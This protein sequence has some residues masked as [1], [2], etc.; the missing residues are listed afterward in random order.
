MAAPAKTAAPPKMAR[1]RNIG[2]VAHIDA[3]KTTV[4]ERFLF[5]SGR[6]HKI[7]EVHDGEAQMDW[8]PQERERGITITAAATSIAWR[9]HDI[10]LIDTP[11]HVDFTIEVERIAARA[12]RRGGRVRRRVGRRAA[13][14]DGV[15]PGRQ[16]SRAAHRVHQQDGPRGRRLRG[17][18]DRDP[19]AAGREAGTAAASD[20]RRGQVRRRR[21]SDPPARAV[22][23]GRRDRGA[24]RG[25]RAGGD[26]RRGRGGARKADRGG[27][28]RR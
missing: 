2:I 6:I 23:L 18:R 28:R 24:A 14:R 12:G 4:T 5:H 3:G 21:R 15:A 27:G 16:V 25:R 20:R 7:G 9:N 11:G 22:F 8:M 26:G 1:V 10:H 17:G 19:R 13:V